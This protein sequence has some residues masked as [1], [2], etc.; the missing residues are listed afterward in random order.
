MHFI[1]FQSLV[2]IPDLNRNFKNSYLPNRSSKLSETCGTGSKIKLP[3]QPHWIHNFRI[4]CGII[5][6]LKVKLGFETYKINN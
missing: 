5:D 6:D 1:F 2:Q 3:T 4:F